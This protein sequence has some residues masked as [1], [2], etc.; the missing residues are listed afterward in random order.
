MRKICA[1]ILLSVFLLCG[2]CALSKKPKVS[3]LPKC[4]GTVFIGENAFGLDVDF[5]AKPENITIKAKNNA[6]DTLYSLEGKKI[7][8][9]YDDII[10]T[11]EIGALP[12][13]NTAC[14]IYKL[15]HAIEKEKVRWEKNGSLYHFYGSLNGTAF[16]GECDKEGK[17]RSF[18]IPLY[19]LYF[20]AKTFTATD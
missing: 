10:T 14:L 1:V 7:T 15:M 9:Q 8:L 13:T 20:K 17:I 5:T 19:K 6:F 2:G 3:V 18:E 12:D 11:L 16:S 4:N